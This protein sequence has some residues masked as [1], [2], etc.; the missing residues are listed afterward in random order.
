MK[1]LLTVIAALLATF[2]F[3]T[4]A[5]YSFEQAPS[6]YTALT[7]PIQIHG[8]GVDDAISAPIEIGFSFLY[9]GT[10][11]TQF[12]ASTNGFIT[13]DLDLNSAPYNLL[14][15]HTLVLGALWDD[16]ATT[17]NDSS[18]SY[19][20]SGL[21][22]NQVLTVQ[23]QNLNW[24]FGAS[25]QNLVNFQ[26]RLRQGSNR[27][28]FVYGLLGNAPGASASASIGISGAVSGDFISVTPAAPQA[29]YSSTEEFTGVNGSHVP[30]LFG[31]QY[32]FV[33]TPALEND[34]A[35]LEVTGNTTPSEGVETVH[36]VRIQNLGSQSQNLYTVRLFN[37]N[38]EELGFS[39][40]VPIAPGEWTQIP[41]AWTPASFGPMTIYGKV[42]LDG[43]EN[44]ANNQS[45]ELN[46][47]VQP[48]GYVWSGIVGSGHESLRVPVDMY[49]KNSLFE[50]IIYPSEMNEFT[51]RF[52]GLRFFNNFTSN[53]T[54]KPVLVWMGTT[55]LPDLADGWIPSTDL[56]LVF[57]GLVDFPSGENVI[58]LPF[59]QAFD[60]FNRDN[61]VI[62]AQRPMDSDYYSSSD[63][64]R[65]QTWGLNRA[66][67]AQSD[68]TIFDPA[69]PPANATVSGEFPQ[70]GFVWAY[71]PVG[72]LQGSV[73]GTGDQPVEGATIQVLDT[74]YSAST[75]AAG[76]YIIHL[77]VGTYDLMIS[78]DGYVDQSVY[79]VIVNLDQTTI[80]NFVLSLV[81]G[82]D[83]LVPPASTAILGIN[84]NPFASLATISFSLKGPAPVRLEIFNSRGQKVRA[85]IDE[86]RTGG[87]QE[88]VWDGLD[89][90]GQ[91]V[92]AGVYLL[93]LSSQGFHCDKRLVL[94]K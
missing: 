34:L 27:V 10:Y 76:N 48:G 69:N 65:S 26:I 59:S 36:Q 87:L 28:E 17:Y 73:L 3:A 81:A 78:A 45:P 5:E 12:R 23:F 94:L 1:T 54:S 21:A 63:Y 7:N 42:F 91:R 90:S 40:G 61:L 15:S 74:G 77:P 31:Y 18:V 84:P 43:D 55:T 88:A 56:T 89:G 62:L 46:L 47:I 58:D 68:N 11:H 29:S 64:F 82:S 66:R 80:L 67:K 72:N 83:P 19:E 92:S 49:W 25:P 60:Y 37:G 13:F 4:L 35:A 39:A 24:Y 71:V 52:T 32:S 2:G 38:D 70:T 86:I 14:N 8:D 9:D 44:P 30:Y 16:L 51:G 93:R 53:L 20:L 41:I 85:L 33:P 79:G 75:D 50:C 22:P 6:G 57:N